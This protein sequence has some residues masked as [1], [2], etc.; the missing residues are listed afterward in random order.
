MHRHHHHQRSCVPLWTLARESLSRHFSDIYPP[1]SITGALNTVGTENRKALKRR[2][3]NSN[4]Q[5]H[6]SLRGS[7]PRM[8]LS[9]KQHVLPRPPPE[10]EQERSQDFSLG[11]IHFRGINFWGYKSLYTPPPLSTP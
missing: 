3:P 10:A 8:I 5:D 11:G 4:P 9:S 2:N 6:K 1:S 7:P